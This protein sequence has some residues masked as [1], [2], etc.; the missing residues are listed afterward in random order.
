MF[1]NDIAAR[2]AKPMEKTTDDVSGPKGT[3]RVFQPICTPASTS[4]S[5]NP[6]LPPI[7]E[8]MKT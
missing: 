2:V 3:S 5:A 4:C 1:P 6:G 8:D 7:P